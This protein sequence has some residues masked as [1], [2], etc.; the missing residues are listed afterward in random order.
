ML[1]D[2][3]TVMGIGDGGAHVGTICDGSGPTFLLTHWA[4]DRRRGSRLAIERLIRKQTMD[5]AHS[6]GLMD[7]G[8]ILPGLRAD[9]NLIDLN[10]LT[11][12]RP[13]MAHD[14]PAGGK[15]FLQKATG[16]RHTFVAGVETLRNDQLT[17]AAPGRLVRGRT[18]PQ[19]A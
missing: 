13:Y 2:E 10:A 4:R 6:Y 16:Y 5:S 19:S 1:E 18:Q 11:L 17:G 7:R 3:A 15:R 14:L 12:H 8:A 9:L